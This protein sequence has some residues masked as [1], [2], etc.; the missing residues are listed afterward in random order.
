MKEYDHRVGAIV[1]D[2][3]PAPLTMRVHQ[4]AKGMGCSSATLIRALQLIG[5]DAKNPSSLVTLQP[6][7]Q[8]VLW[9]FIIE[10]E[11]H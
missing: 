11:G 9:D 2:L 4:F 3:P 8:D 1:L 6:I 5:H 10:R 7:E